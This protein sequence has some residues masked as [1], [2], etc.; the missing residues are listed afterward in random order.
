LSLVPELTAD[1]SGVAA[2]DPVVA[3]QVEIQVKYASYI[4]RQERQVERFRGLEAHRIPPGIDYDSVVG[5]RNESREKLEQLRPLSVGQASRISGVTPADVGV[6]M[7]H[8]EKIQAGERYAGR[9]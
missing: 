7:A 9:A 6:L 4:E 3:E 2:V 5:I 1:N 8:I